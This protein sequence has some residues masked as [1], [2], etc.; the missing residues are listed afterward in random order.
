ML[1]GET[2][3]RLTGLSFSTVQLLKRST[4]QLFHRWNVPSINRFNVFKH[5]LTVIP[6]NCTA[7]QLFHSLTVLPLNRLNS[8]Y[9]FSTQTFN[10][11]NVPSF[12]CFTN[13]QVQ[14]PQP[15]TPSTVSQFNCFTVR[16]FHLSAG[17]T[18]SN[19]T[20]LTVPL[21]IC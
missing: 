9:R 11:S 21:F 4:V 6:L 8:L 16:L 13:H 14:P 3:N 19:Y 5:P 12:N 2:V 17:S 10:C 1:N 15:F 18:L 20:H 7:V